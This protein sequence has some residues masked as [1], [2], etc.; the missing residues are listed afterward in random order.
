MTKV[1][2]VEA[3]FI[4]RTPNAL[5]VSSV[6]FPASKNRDTIWLYLY[7]IEVFRA[8]HDQPISENDKLIRGDRL[9]ISLPEWM[10]KER[11]MI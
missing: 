1:I 2:T 7:E 5:C 8:R 11:E 6:G 4:V 10:A 3:I 9:E